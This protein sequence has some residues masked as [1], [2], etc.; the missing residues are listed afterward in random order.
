VGAGLAITTPL[1]TLSLHWYNARPRKWP[2]ID[3]EAYG[4]KAS[5]Q[6]RWRGGALLYQL[7]ISPLSQNDNDAFDA[8]FQSTPQQ[9]ELTVLF[10][11]D[12]GFQLCSGSVGRSDIKD[13]VD[14]SGK[15]ARIN[16]IGSWQHCS[17]SDYRESTKWNL[18]WWGLSKV[19]EH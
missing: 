11:D 15:I 1:V 17:Y 18:V 13:E 4:V 19:G 9:F 12:S 3:I 7:Y 2:S 10:H 16:A 8:A 6:T 5:L 14:R